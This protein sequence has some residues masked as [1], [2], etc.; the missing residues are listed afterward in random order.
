MSERGPV[1]L[2]IHIGIQGLAGY[3]IP[4]MLL[5]CGVL[6]WF[7]PAQRAFYSLLA[8]VL[9][10]GSWVTSNLGGFFLGMLLGL[11]GGALAFAWA[12]G[13]DDKPLRW[14]RGDPQILQP[15]WG[16]ELV[17]HPTA[18]LPPPRRVGSIE[19]AGAAY[20]SGTYP[21]PAVI[22]YGSK[23]ARDCESASAGPD[24]AGPDGASRTRYRG[25]GDASATTGAARPPPGTPPHWPAGADC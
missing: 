13:S 11:I 19:S 15:S 7:N 23:D 24:G 10:L 3:L 2:V 12:I 6:L 18:M 1:A 22:V 17:L 4:V 21:S 25:E 14:F 9:A 5:L 8:I 20:S 16:L